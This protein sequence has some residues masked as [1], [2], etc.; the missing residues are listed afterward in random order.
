[1]NP[2]GAGYGVMPYQYVT[3]RNTEAFT[4]GA[5]VQIEEPSAAVITAAGDGTRTVTLTL[6]G[7]V[8]LVIE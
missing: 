8:N 6:R 7:N 4:L 5:P 3:D 1:M 2:Y